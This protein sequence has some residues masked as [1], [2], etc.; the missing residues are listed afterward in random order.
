MDMAL[1]ENQSMIQDLAKKFAA[2]ELEPVADNLM[3]EDGREIF[4]SN[5]KK[6]PE[7]LPLAFFCSIYWSFGSNTIRV[8]DAW[9]CQLFSCLSHKAHQN[10]KPP[11]PI[12]KKPMAMRS[13]HCPRESWW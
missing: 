7:D 5:L 3:A 4:L 1:N 13:I 8:K 6:R 11:K 12:E 2:T 9:S 10:P